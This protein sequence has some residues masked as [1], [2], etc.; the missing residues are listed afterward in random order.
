MACS[1]CSLNFKVFTPVLW[2]RGRA[3]LSCTHPSS[4]SHYIWFQT[5][6]HTKRCMLQFACQ[7]LITV[8]AD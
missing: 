6:V 1:F 2:P 8:L 3:M 7:V 4:L 5:Q